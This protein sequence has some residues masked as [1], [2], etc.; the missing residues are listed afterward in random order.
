MDKAIKVIWDNTSAV[1]R[2]TVL[3]VVTV[4]GLLA[5]GDA[6]WGSASDVQENEKDIKELRMKQYITSTEALIVDKKNQYGCYYVQMDDG[7]L[8]GT[9]IEKCSTPIPPDDRIKIKD[10]EEDV[11]LYK[12]IV[13]DRERAR[14]GV[15]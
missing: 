3:I 11:E 8:H 10:W 15:E 1:V 13:R 6:R 12:G 7:S 5:W 9:A 2:Y 14:M 4:V